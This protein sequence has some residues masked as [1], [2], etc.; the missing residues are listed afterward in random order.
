MLRA[1]AHGAPR[2]SLSEMHVP[3]E[4]TA[5]HS[6]AWAACAGVHRRG[7]F[8]HNPR[9]QHHRELYLRKWHSREAAGSKRSFVCSVKSLLPLSNWRGS[10]QRGA[11]PADKAM[12]IWN[13]W[14]EEKISSSS[15]ELKHKRLRVGGLTFTLMVYQAHGGSSPK[16][17]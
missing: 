4:L 16:P 17:K 15:R 7:P 10:V 3:S 12:H 13:F 8:S 2:G 9:F 6:L 5:C 14:T 1:A 11:L